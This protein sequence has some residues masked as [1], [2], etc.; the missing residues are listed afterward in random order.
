M[1]NPKKYQP[2]QQQTREF[3]TKWQE[4]L[5]LQHW[6]ITVGFKK[7]DEANAEVIFAP[8]GVR[9]E[10]SFDLTK[11]E[12]NS[13]HHLEMIVVHEMVHII[14]RHQVRSI[15]RLYDYSYGT[16]GD[17]GAS[18]MFEFACHEED[19]CDHLTKVLMEL[20]ND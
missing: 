13:D 2:T 3:V 4:L 16:N 15:K 17:I 18:L 11:K 10:I 19:L 20:H 6:D 5:N 7:L 8:K 9:C 12:I 1:T 14:S